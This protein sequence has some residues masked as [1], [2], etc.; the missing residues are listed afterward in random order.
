MRD[1]VNDVDAGHADRRRRGLL[2]RQH[3]VGDAGVTPARVRAREAGGVVDRGPEL[4]AEVVSAV[5]VAR[6]RGVLEAER[7]ERLA[8]DH[9]LVAAQHQR[10]RRLGAEELEGAVA[11]GAEVDERLFHDLAGEIAERLLHQRLGAVGRAGVEDEVAVDVRLHRGDRLLDGARLVL[12][13]HHQP[14]QRSLFG[15]GAFIG[16]VRAER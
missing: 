14:K 16:N 10:E 5:G 2:L 6:P 4:D 12:D 7:A 3:L 15:H 9:G 1:V 13:D 8:A 11:R